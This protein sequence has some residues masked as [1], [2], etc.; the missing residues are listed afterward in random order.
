MARLSSVRKSD[1]SPA[2]LA[3]VGGHERRAVRLPGE[4]LEEPRRDADL[5]EQEPDDLALF[6]ELV[7][8]RGEQAPFLAAGVR[9]TQP[10]DDVDRGVGGAQVLAEVSDQGGALGADAAIPMRRSVAGIRHRGH[11]EPDEHR[12]AEH[13]HR[14]VSVGTNQ[15]SRLSHVR[16]PRGTIAIEIVPGAGDARR[17]SAAPRRQVDLELGARLD[18]HAVRSRLLGEGDDSE[19]IEQTDARVADAA[20]RRRQ[21]LVPDRVGAEVSRR[22][23]GRTRR[24]D[25][26]ARRA[27]SSCP[28]SPAA[29][30]LACARRHGAPGS[31]AVGGTMR[32]D[33]PRRPARRSA[34]TSV[35]AAATSCRSP[36]SVGERT[37]VGGVCSRRSPVA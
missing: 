13:A 15:T 37:A 18:E 12:G 16:P 6:A 23:G 19:A 34:T 14:E 28:R 1:R 33:G 22:G 10:L 24:A 8:Q 21:P 26:S 17:E 35:C 9:Q 2:T 11:A 5:L 29:W 27:P 7:E 30:G 4:T 3:A 25:A 31:T 32:G 20:W 36:G